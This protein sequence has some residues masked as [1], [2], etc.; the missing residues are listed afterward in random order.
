MTNV[1]FV[2]AGRTPFGNFGGALKD[3]TVPELGAKAL[4]GTLDRAGLQGDE[5]E[6]IAFGVNFPGG[7]RS[8]TRQAMLQAGLPEERVAYTVDRA[9]CSSMAAINLIAR[10]LRCGD[11]RIGIAGG[12]ENLSAVPYFI[13]Q[14]R[15]GN[16]LGDFT[17]KDQLV[18]SCPHTG[19]PR[20]VQAGT[21]SM[22]YDIGRDVQD[23]WALQS[24]QRYFSALD[25]GRFKDEILPITIL[26]K[27]DEIVLDHDEPARRDTSLERLARLK[28]VYG[29]PTVTPGNAPGLNTGASAI[30]MMEEEEASRRGLKPLARYVAGAMVSGHPQKL[31]SIPAIAAEA[32]L[33]KADLRLDQIDLLEINEAFA[34]MPLV[35]THVLG[36]GDQRTIERLR[37]R[38]NV[39]GGAIAI[40]HPTG[41]TAARLVMTLA[42][43][44]R[45]SGKRYGLATLCGGIG[46]G[47]AVIIE[48][49]A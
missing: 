26:Q 24:H 33:K 38:T 32:A 28:T 42:Y 30:I 14:A 3:F 17:V 27:S 35:S 40:G 44:L 48:S 7:D 18:I 46:E 5:V 22:E 16:R 31:A 25:A 8:I 45:R 47:E 20:A 4:R 9:C 21:E 41:A 34:A 6:E 37:E 12:A 2:N 29:S 13:P 23:A 36:R 10:G 11:I 49:L 1:V 15:W 43:E 39:N 19:V